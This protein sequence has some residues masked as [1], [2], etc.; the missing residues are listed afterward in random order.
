MKVFYV[1][2]CSQKF[3]KIH[4]KTPATLFKKRL[5]HRCFPVNFVKFLRAP[6][7]TEHLWTTASRTVNKWL[8]TILICR[9]SPIH[10]I[11]NHWKNNKNLC[12]VFLF[13]HTPFK[14]TESKDCEWI[15]SKMCIM[16]ENH[17]LLLEAKIRK[18]VLDNVKNFATLDELKT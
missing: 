1:K 2:R 9:F 16:Q 17:L 14:L 13:S 15:E 3:H 6:F 7:Y 18:L 12:W 10:V 8:L 4:R 11:N 5:W